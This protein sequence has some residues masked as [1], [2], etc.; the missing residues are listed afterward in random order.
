MES[1]VDGT[2]EEPVRRTARPDA[3][4]VE[5]LWS[6]SL[7]YNFNMIA[8][9]Y[10]IH[11]KKTVYIILSC[12]FASMSLIIVW[13]EI[14][15]GIQTNLSPIGA[16]LESLHNNVSSTEKTKSRLIELIALV[17]LAYMSVCVYSSLFKLRIFGRYGLRKGLSDGGALIFNA[18]VS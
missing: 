17:P 2:I 5:K 8:Y 1:Y 10:D 18:E 14:F 12:I 4:F 13:S 3:G 11:L 15:M 9:K 6:G 7:A 16:I